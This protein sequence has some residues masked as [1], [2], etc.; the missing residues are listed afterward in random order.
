MSRS[1][2]PMSRGGNCYEAPT[3]P[4]RGERWLVC[5]ITDLR[6]PESEGVW[7]RGRLVHRSAYDQPGY[8][9]LI[10][11]SAEVSIRP[12]GRDTFDVGEL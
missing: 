6:F 9:E 8:R 1:V 3:F 10:D 11:D 4:V 12:S 5:P 7:S 2:R